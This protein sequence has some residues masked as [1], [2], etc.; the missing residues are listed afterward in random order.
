[1]PKSVS[2]LRSAGNPFDPAG[3][4]L[5]LDHVEAV[6]AA[7]SR[8]LPDVERPEPDWRLVGQWDRLDTVREAVFEIAL[9]AGVNPAHRSMRLEHARVVA[10]AMDVEAELIRAALR[11]GCVL[12][13]TTFEHLSEVHEFVC[14]VVEQAME[15]CL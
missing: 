13:L 6:R 1:M 4:G 8:L 3:Y 9:D 15:P 12:S 5:S 10:E 7:I 14:C 11:R 2:E